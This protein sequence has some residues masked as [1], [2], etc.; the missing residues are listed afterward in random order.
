MG[1]GESTQKSSKESD[2]TA[3]TLVANTKYVNVGQFVTSNINRAFLAL[4]QKKNKFEHSNCYSLLYTL[5]QGTITSDQM[6]SRESQLASVIF[7]GVTRIT[8][9]FP[10]NYYKMFKIISKETNS[11]I[12]DL[13]TII[14]FLLEKKQEWIRNPSKFIS[15][16]LKKP[17]VRYTV[18]LGSEAQARSLRDA[19]YEETSSAKSAG[20]ADKCYKSNIFNGAS[21]TQ[22]ENCC[23]CG[24]RL[25][26]DSPDETDIEHVVSS[27]L[28]ILLGI[29]PA[30]KSWTKFWKV[31][32]VLSTGEA[33]EANWVTQ[34][35]SFFPKDEQEDARSVFRSM[36]LPA[37][38]GCNR[39]YKREWS[40][41]GIKMSAIRGETIGNITGNINEKF[42]DMN[43]SYVKKV[44][45][46]SINDVNTKLNVIK[47]KHLYEYQRN[48]IRNQTIVFNNIAWL[49]DSIDQRNNKASL[50]LIQILYGYAKNSPNAMDRSAFVELISDLLNL[51]KG[52]IVW[53]RI[54]SIL[55]NPKAQLIIIT[56]LTLVVEALLVVFQ[57][58][59]QI[60]T[61]VLTFEAT[62]PGYSSPEYLPSQSGESSESE[63]SPTREKVVR[64]DEIADLSPSG[65]PDLLTDETYDRSTSGLPDVLTDETDD[66]ST[67]GLLVNSSTDNRSLI[68]GVP[69][70]MG[71][72]YQQSTGS[73]MIVPTTL[74]SD[75][76]PYY[77]NELSNRGSK[78]KNSNKKSESSSATSLRAYRR[79]EQKK[80][81]ENTALDNLVTTIANDAI[82]NIYPDD[83]LTTLRKN[84]LLNIA[85]PVALNVL[86][87]IRIDINNER[88]RSARQR[89]Y[90]AVTNTLTENNKREAAKSPTNNS[91]TRELR[92]GSR[93]RTTRRHSTRKR[94]PSKKPRRTIRRQRRNNKRTQK[95]RK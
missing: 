57:C 50:S 58:E 63:S 64:I 6:C 49:L 26:S 40:P 13:D 45:I 69:T 43:N 29:C 75:E 77:G 14:Q 30:S 15:N 1:A 41:F 35:I 12:T 27:Q 66:S 18:A 32:N 73:S 16:I 67:S 81:N 83:N 10:E 56:K 79:S 55:K 36:M 44:I 54:D 31:F 20:G 78:S 37:H 47:K 61:E 72:P 4:Q 25:Y 9:N 80:E 8:E 3:S 24:L 94:R 22:K 90:E 5:T 19:C 60:P 59:V 70:L 46:P 91:F 7:E 68:F 85:K 39:T 53:D 42:K 93:K 33:V 76:T 87:N 34:L 65:L 2:G 84:Y 52:L 51:T 95:R 82:N 71:V 21:D 28:L 17:G 92:G 86:K 23:I 74:F 89:A 11:N 62:N 88:N 38:P 48:W